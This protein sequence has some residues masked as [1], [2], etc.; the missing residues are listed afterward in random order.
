M[1]FKDR[2][3]VQ[4]NCQVTTGV[5]TLFPTLYFFDR[6]LTPEKSYHICESAVFFEPE[7]PAVHVA[8]LV[9]I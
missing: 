5:G 7:A 8:V 4:S 1:E 3:H 9:V 2:C 6:L